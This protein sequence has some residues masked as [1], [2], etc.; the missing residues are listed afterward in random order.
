[1]GQQIQ[2]RFGLSKQSA[3][4]VAVTAHQFNKLA[5]SRALTAEDASAFSKDLIGFDMGQIETAV[6]KSAKGESSDLK[7]L[8][9]KASQNMGTSPEQFNKILTEIFY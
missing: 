4:K 8:V 7:S 6:R 5:G 9:D 1:M 3:Q 2:A